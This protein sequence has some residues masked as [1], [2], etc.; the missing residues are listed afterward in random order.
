MVLEVANLVAVAAL[1]FNVAV[2]VPAVNAPFAS[3]A[4][5][6]FAVLDDVPVVAV[7][8][9]FPAVDM[10]AKFASVIPAV[11]DKFALVNPEI[12]LLDATIVLLVKDSV[13]ASVAT[14]PVVG[15][16]ISVA[17]VVFNVI[18]LPDPLTPVVVKAAPVVM[19]PP[20]VMVFPV[21]SIPVPPFAPD[22][23][24]VI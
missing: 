24:P 11:P 1:P 22:T 9:T 23:I 21:L 18:A 4:T 15:N 20:R 14:V 2:I 3:L 17:P 19:L 13:P 7:F 6:A 10:V 8:A 16:I 12:L 5:I